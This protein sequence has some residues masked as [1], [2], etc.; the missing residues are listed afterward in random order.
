MNTENTLRAAG[1]PDFADVDDWLTNVLIC[2]GVMPNRE[3]F[4]HIK[5]AVMLRLRKL[6][7]DNK[8]GIY[9]ALAK[10][11]GRRADGIERNIRSAIRSAYDAGRLCNINKLFGIRVVDEHT[12]LTSIELISLLTQYA[13]IFLRMRTNS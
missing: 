2:I 7:P 13:T 8:N 10:T 9:S 4:L 12:C 6:S 5:N 1:E 11:C 3:G